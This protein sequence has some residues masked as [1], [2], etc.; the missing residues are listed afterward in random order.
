M[1]KYLFVGV[2]PSETASARGWTWRH[3]R[4]AAVPLFD[5]LRCLG[6]EPLEQRFTNLFTPAG[7]V[8]RWA[9]L[10]IRQWAYE[11]YTV[12]ALGQ[13]VSKALAERGIEHI[14]LIHPAARGKIRKRERYREHV[15]ERLI[16]KE[17]STR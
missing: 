5:A 1:P 4:L 6:I 16:T 2:C 12:V 15:R 7:E 9:P 13:P 17:V 8:K 10:R 14:Q 3:G 11:G